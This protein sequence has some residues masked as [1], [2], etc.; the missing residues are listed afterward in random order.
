METETPPQS[1]TCVSQPID[2]SMIQSLWLP[3]TAVDMDPADEDEQQPPGAST[4]PPQSFRVPS[5]SSH[6]TVLSPTSPPAFPVWSS[7]SAWVVQKSTTAA[8]SASFCPMRLKKLP[9]SLTETV[10]GMRSGGKA[11]PGGVGS[12]LQSSKVLSPTEAYVQSCQEQVR[13]IAEY[14]R[15]SLVDIEGGKSNVRIIILILF[16]TYFQYFI[17]ITKH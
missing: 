2:D 17:L 3:Y 7:T 13:R 1:P 11:P 6:T 5:I 12:A 16:L 8:A 4:E 10:K 14:S 9:S 15:D